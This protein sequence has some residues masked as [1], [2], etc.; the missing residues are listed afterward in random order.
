MLPASDVDRLGA[1]S[2]GK[3]EAT[4]YPKAFQWVTIWQLRHVTNAKG[5]DRRRS[6]VPEGYAIELIETSNLM[7]SI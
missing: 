7:R 6:V 2:D 5:I 4:L 3:D 1:V